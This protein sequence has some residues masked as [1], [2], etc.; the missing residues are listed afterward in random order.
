VASAGDAAF[1]HSADSSSALVVGPGKQI[2][3][4]VIPVRVRGD[5]TVQF[6]GDQ[7]TGCA[8]RGLCGFSGT[9]IW[10]PSRTAML[11]SD[12]FRTSGR[13]EYNVS[14]GFIGAALP[15]GEEVDGGVTTAD[16]R[17]VPNGSVGASTIC[18]DAAAT[19]ADIQM[20]VHLRAAL[21]TLAAATPSL[22]GT[23]CAGPL[24]SDIASVLARRLV[25]VATL[26]HGRV[27]VSLA[28]SADF[29]VHGLAGTVT[30]T[31]QLSLGRAHP[32]RG[33]NGS[34]SPSVPKVRSV[35][36][37]YRAHLDGSVLTH[38]HG[39]PSS[40]G[41]LGSCGANGTFALSLHS[42]P[43]ML[44]IS[45]LTRARRPIRDTLTALGLRNDGN[46]RGIP[47]FGFFIARGP[48][49][50]AVDV[51]LGTTTCRDTGPSGLAAVALG[52]ERG[53]ALASF[54]LWQQAP[55]LRCPGPAFSAAN[56]LASATVRIGGFAPHGGTIH[57]RGG[58]ELNDDG[59]TGHTTAN[60]TLT[61]SR[62]RVSVV[63][64]ALPS[65]APG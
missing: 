3:A 59:Y 9:V 40:C 54:G 18:T 51:T 30:S 15:D 11:E 42:A 41:P 2:S 13:T 19:G 35:L 31:I 36:V 46:P 1:V 58:P 45:A 33:G 21:L 22:L 24:Q 5:L 57:F 38:M 14:L 56:G 25:D 17:F 32:Q 50:Y 34:L 47:V 52:G 60:L 63:N 64:D 43:G 49:T 20:P 65:E 7:A 28:S 23:R 29:A 39:D 62:P 44:T 37:R 55:H 48:A 10:Q 8:A 12:V 53:R 26:S 6:H 4:T 61:I 27:E 16:V